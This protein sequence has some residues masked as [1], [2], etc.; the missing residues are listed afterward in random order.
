MPANIDFD[1]RKNRT[2]RDNSNAVTDYNSH[3]YV[4]L[5]TILEERNVMLDLKPGDTF[6]KTS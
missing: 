5:A 3:I 1:P 2:G 4:T 6:T